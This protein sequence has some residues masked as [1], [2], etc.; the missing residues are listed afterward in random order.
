MP[1]STPN[2]PRRQAG[3][4]RLHWL[5]AAGL[6]LSLGAPVWLDEAATAVVPESAPQGT[7]IGYVEKIVGEL[8]EIRIERDGRLLTPALLLPLQ[9][10]DR[11]TALAPGSELYAQVGNRRVV[12]TLRNSPYSVHPV[13]APPGFI[14]RL[15]ST[16]M[17]V[18][19][20]LTTQYVRSS[21]PV[22]TS[23]RGREGPLSM[24]LVQ[25]GVSRIGTHHAALA[26]AWDGGAAPFHVEVRGPDGHT[27]A[28][29]DA[30]EWRAR[31]PLPARGLVPGL[32]HIVIQD[33]TGDG[34]RRSVDVVPQESVPVGSADLSDQ[35]L[36]PELRTLLAADFLVQT[37]RRIWTFEGYQDVAPLADSYEPA[38]LL[39]DCLEAA[40]SCYHQ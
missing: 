7:G 16:L 31:L 15:G 25:D 29:A 5:A 10:G 37:H 13:G 2:R 27:L 9:A 1:M 8:R 20:R 39:R 22:S 35:D 40:P 30:E 38:R 4:R 11:V 24:P 18:G 12:V 6:A 33:R 21:S 14:T 32:L 28:A 19:A 34:M 17:S 36:P 3:A 26:L 23:S